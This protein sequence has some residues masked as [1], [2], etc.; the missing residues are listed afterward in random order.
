MRPLA[1]VNE[2][3]ER[4]SSAACGED[5]KC[6]SQIIFPNYNG[7]YTTL[8]SCVDSCDETHSCSHNGYQDVSA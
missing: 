8:P 5:C 7:V 3:M 6:T 1:A 4:M 2:A